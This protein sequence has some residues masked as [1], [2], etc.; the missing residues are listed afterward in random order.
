MINKIKNVQPLVKQLL[1]K[2]AEL[3]DC[4]NRLYINFISIADPV[5]RNRAT[6]FNYFAKMMIN[7]NYPPME[8]IT[9]AR[10]KVQE[11]NPELRGKSYKGRKEE[12]KQVKQLINK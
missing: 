11:E 5:L 9:R 2:Y 12:E 1:E 7:G 3:R 10:R 8:S 4:D 6:D